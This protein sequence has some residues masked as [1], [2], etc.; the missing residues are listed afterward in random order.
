MQ[1]NPDTPNTRP[2]GCVFVIESDEVVRSALGFI[3][4]PDRAVHAFAS[5]D[6]AL[7]AAADLQPVIVLLGIDFLRNDGAAVLATLVARVPDAK[8][9]LVANSA[10]DCLA[11]SAL[12][13]GAHEVLG[14]PITHEAVRRKVTALLDTTAAFPTA[15]SGA[16]CDPVGYR[17]RSA[18]GMSLAFEGYTS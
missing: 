13:W 6:P 11:L 16:A 17:L 7:A 2:D 1:I 8:L 5:I 3:L 14:K 9:L 10:R 15:C 12:A 4:K 18:A